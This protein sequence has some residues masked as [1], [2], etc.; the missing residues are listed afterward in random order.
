MNTDK[1][2]PGL[3][4][5]LHTVTFNYIPTD[6]N[7]KNIYNLFSNLQYT[8]PCKY[9]RDSYQIF[10]KYIDIKPF[11]ND[12]MGLIYWL[13]IIHNLVN[14][15]LNKS[16]IPFVKVVEKYEQFRASKENINFNEFAF[17]AKSKYSSTINKMIKKLIQ[18]KIF[19]F[20]ESY[21]H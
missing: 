14:L 11:L 10:F 9:C 17:L 8:L 2:G 20:F 19:P 13:Y 21:E 1:W 4:T 3:W 12:R 7:K 18:S 16:T 6:E 15:K 5:F